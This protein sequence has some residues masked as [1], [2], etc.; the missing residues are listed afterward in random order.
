MNPAVQG[1][2]RDYHYTVTATRDGAESVTHFTITVVAAA[3]LGVTGG[4]LSPPPLT[5]AGGLGLP[6]AQG[7]GR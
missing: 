6:P 1:P 3:G 7:Q 2:P 4:L 5:T